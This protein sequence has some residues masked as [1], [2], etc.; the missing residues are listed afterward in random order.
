MSD[1]SQATLPNAQEKP[2]VAAYQ[3]EHELDGSSWA[4][5]ENLVNML[6]REL[7]GPSGGED[8]IVVGESPVTK[9]ILGRIA[10]T[11]LGTDSDELVATD[12]LGGEPQGDAAQEATDDEAFRSEGEGTENQDA[13]Q[14]RG[15]MI[16]ASMGLRFQIP[17]TLELVTVH[18]RWGSYEPLKSEETS[19]T[20]RRVERFGREQH[21]VPVT[22]RFDSLVPGKTKDIPVGESATLRVDS[23]EDEANQRFL[24]ELALCNDLECVGK[25]MARDWMFQTQLEVTA[26]GEAAFL[27]VH[28][29]L[30]DESFARERDGEQRRINLQYRDRLEYAIG[31]TC[32]VDWDEAPGARR[33]TAVRTTWVPSAE[34]P[35]TRATV[36]EGAVLNMEELAT[37]DASGAERAL[38]PI[39]RAYEDWLDGQ[40]RE[41]WNLPEHLQPTALEAVEEARQVASQ[42]NGGI[43]YLVAHKEALVCFRFMNRVMADQ[44][45]HSQVAA[46]RAANPSTAP[47]T[48]EAEVRAGSYPHHWRA[49]QLAFVLMQVE[50]LMEPSVHVRSGA[51]A[52]AQLIFFPTGGGK[53]EAY[54]GLAAFAFAARRRQG[55]VQSPDG[56]LDPEGVT[57][58]MRYTLRLLTSQQFQRAAALVCAAELERRR[59]PELW[60]K[61]PF[62]LGLWVGSNVTPKRVSEVRDDIKRASNQGGEAKLDVLQLAQCPWCGGELGPGDVRVD[63]VSSRVY[64]H[65]HDE[66]GDCPFC[67]GGE[68]EEGI[69]VLTT[70]EEIYRLVPSFVIATV[71]KFARLAREG[72]AS[73]LFGYVGRKCDRHGY[74]PQ[75]ATDG[76]SDYAECSIKDDSCHPAKDSYP[77][78]YVHP[79]NRLRPP[80]LIIQDELHLI[81]GS[82]G[83]TV[84]LFESAID[85]LCSWRDNHGRPVKPLVVASSA[86]MR[87][88]AEQ[89]RGLYGRGTTVFPPQV[90]NASDT[91]FSKEV[92]PTRE[93]PGRRYVGISA[94]GVRFTTAE[95]Q[96]AELLMKGAQLLFDEAGP[97]ADPYMTLVEYFSA[98]REL[99]GMARYMADDVTSVLRRVRKETG[100]HRRYGSLLSALNVGELTSRISS[101]DIVGTL[102]RMAV[103]FDP[104]FDATQA[105]FTRLEAR[106][107]GGKALETRH[108]AEAPFDAV[109]ATSM[110][111]V[112]V[113]VPRL[114]LMVVAGQPKNTAE[115][116]Q[117]SS[118]V[119]RDPSRPGL[120]VSLGNWSRPRDLAH[121]EQFRTYHESFYARVEPLSV[122]PYSATSLERG[123]A[124]LLVSLARVLQANDAHGGLSPEP[125]AGRIG[126]DGEQKFL[127]DLIEERLLP[128]MLSASNEEARQFARDQ[129]ANRLCAWEDYAEDAAKDG[130]SLVYEKSSDSSRTRPLIAASESVDL[131]SGGAFAVANSMREVQ[132]EI[133][134]LVS[135]DPARMRFRMKGEPL[136]DNR[137][138]KDGKS[139]KQEEEEAEDEE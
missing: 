25:I 13:P 106:K 136:W 42:L 30:L 84:G 40:E 60:G 98:T 39:A 33:A 137:P 118:R 5:R 46:K 89:I 49:F 9:Y 100:F 132:P 51:L 117:A 77:K 131:T 86:T 7:V 15:L 123:T 6:G 54:L 134:I 64:V 18:C 94:S 20:G 28:D 71:D 67:E 48:A 65:C 109:L 120:V 66:T 125:S 36:V 114:G 113:D 37:V 29:W 35:Q 72:Q 78:A 105:I 52:R 128:R 138:T 32:S 130:L 83:T 119:G 10:P 79:T 111:Q 44:R 102:N 95:I 31:R 63:P 87:N 76:S 126:E 4:V 34:I 68:V 70:D 23:Y 92:P 11:K 124:G 1:N 59:H 69:P 107:N 108:D 127:A 90:L 47:A 58:L 121:Y 19:A 3:L 74:V 129:L 61:E 45:V 38:R 96:V 115:Y 81:T 91:F 53:T 80:D 8:E 43:D 27:P 85:I 93:D 57:V 110:L 26:G 55:F 21:D 50:A 14:Q 122:T 75:L 22:V 88:A 135:P 56:R 16:P 24:V 116:I 112:G 97:A 17:K 139:E 99:A 41:A 62:R 73:S 82:L 101:G 12:G 103:P 104:G 133:N 2:T